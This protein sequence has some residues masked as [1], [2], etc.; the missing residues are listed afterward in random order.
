IHVNFLDL[1]APKAKVRSRILIGSC[2][3]S[4]E[5]TDQD[6]PNGKLGALSI[7]NDKLAFHFMN[8]GSMEGYPTATVSSDFRR[9]DFK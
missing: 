8:Y 5:L 7:L 4:I 6:I 1:S 9:L 3:E 2:Q